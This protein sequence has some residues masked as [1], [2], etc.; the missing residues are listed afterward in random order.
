MPGYVVLPAS[1]D[2]VVEIVNLANEFGLSYVVR[3]NGGSVFGLV[4]SDGIVTDM[5]RM[6]SIVIDKE[7]WVAVVEPGATSF[8]V[9][10]EAYKHGFRVNVAEPAAT[11]CGNII[12]TGIFS[13]WSNAY[14][15]AADNLVNGEFVDNQGNVFSLADRDCP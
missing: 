1:R 14:G 13:T 11:V 10:M 9:Q 7:N 8:D 3:G 4:F 2:E 12:C 6:K 5:N 15:V